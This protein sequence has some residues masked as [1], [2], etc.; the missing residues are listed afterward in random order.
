M[1][2]WCIQLLGLAR[3]PGRN[4]LTGPSMDDKSKRKEVDAA[5]ISLDLSMQ[6]KDIFVRI[7]HAGGREEL[8]QNVVPASQLMEKYPGLCVARPEVFKNPQ[9]ALL[10]PD[11]I[12]LIGKKYYMIPCTTAQKI[13]KKHQKKLK[14]KEAA[15]GKDEAPDGKNTV[16]SGGSDTD[17]SVC[18]DKEYYVSKERW[19]KCLRRKGFRGKKPF[20]PPLPRTRSCR[21]I[22]WEPSLTSVQE[23]SP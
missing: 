11:E 7:V 10:R 23:L 20:V 1:L 17:D 2:K 13:K 5:S 22:N 16:D 3:N 6:S 19:S 8:Y 4:Q 21:G 14:A 18:S 12:L 15:E 9:E